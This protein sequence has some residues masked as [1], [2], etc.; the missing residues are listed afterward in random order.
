M[1]DLTQ[2]LEASE[3]EAQ[4]MADALEQMTAQNSALERDVQALQNDNDRLR[5]NNDALAAEKYNLS[6]AN[7][8]LQNRLQAVSYMQ[9]HHKGAPDTMLQ[10]EVH[11]L[12]LALNEERKVTEKLSRNLE[13]EKRRSE[14]LEQKAKN[15]FRKSG[16]SGSGNVALF[17]P[18]DM[19][20]RD[21]NLQ[22]TMNK[23]RDQLERLMQNLQECEE[24]VTGFEIQEEYHAADLHKELVNLKK[25]LGDE[26]RRSN[27]DSNKLTEL[28]ALFANSMKSYNEAVEH[29]KQLEH[30]TKKNSEEAAAEQRSHRD[31]NSPSKLESLQTRLAQAQEDIRDERRRADQVAEKLRQCQVDLETLPILRAQVEVYQTDFE[32]ERSAREKIAGE[33][34][35][36]ADELLRLKAAT[37]HKK[38]KDN[39]LALPDNDA[40]GANRHQ[41]PEIA[42]GAV[43]DAVNQFAPADRAETR[44]TTQ[45]GDQAKKQFSC[46]KCNKPFPILT[47]LQNHVNACLDRD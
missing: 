29:A 33:K 32:A 37:G 45:Q 9:N 21:E 4:R 12:H 47:L 2:R 26:K 43:R 34:A 27:S 17:L 31:N 7:A 23:Y 22:D 44:Q 19:R 30:K 38:Q 18:E 39:A 8:D 35:D 40:A 11:K 24:K 1:A 16:P 41:R 36:V 10:E 6:A 5:G 25:V 28:Q 3:I 14:S 42:T 15:A 13:L 20:F 46:P